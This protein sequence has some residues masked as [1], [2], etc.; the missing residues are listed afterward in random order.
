[1]LHRRR[2]CPCDSCLSNDVPSETTCAIGNRFFDNPFGRSE[3]RHKAREAARATTRAAGAA[4]FF[5][6]L[7]ENTI[8]FVRAGG[9]EDAEAYPDKP[10]Y[11]GIVG[12]DIGTTRGDLAWRAKRTTTIQDGIAVRKGQWLVRI[13]W[14]YYCADAPV[15]TD[16]PEILLSSPPRAYRCSATEGT[17]IW[18][19]NSLV[20]TPFFED[21]PKQMKNCGDTGGSRGRS[22]RRLLELT[23]ASCTRISRLGWRFE[24][25]SRALRASL[26]YGFPYIYRTPIGVEAIRPI[27]PS[28]VSARLSA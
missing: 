2:P 13:R 23:A 24:S 6:R 8:I 26:N 1:M 16:A 12:Y 20:T 21:A 22:T 3:I 9:T 10:Y 18:P 25:G 19:G 4:A 15:P 11:L 7:Q 5:E 17:V 28:H 14:L 27:F